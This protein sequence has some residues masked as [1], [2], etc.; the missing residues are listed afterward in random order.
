[1]KRFAWPN[2]SFQ[3]VGQCVWQRVFQCVLSRQSRCHL[4][5]AL[6]FTVLAAIPCLAAAPVRIAIVQGGGS[7]IEQDVVDRLTGQLQNMEDVVIS[8][9]N[10]DWYVVCNIQEKIDQLSGQVRYNGN[11]IVKTTDGQVLGTYAV[12]KYNQDFSLTPGASV[13]KALVDGAARDVI[14]QLVN[15]VLPPIQQA[16]QI[17]IETRE[18]VAR[19]NEL[20][21]QD[22]Y[23]DALSLLEPITPDTPHFKQVEKIEQQFQIEK[24]ALSLIEAGQDKQRSGHYLEAINLYRNVSA[25]S[26]RSKLAKEKIAQCSAAISH[27]PAGKASRNQ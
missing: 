17:E 18:R 3:C 6:A 8:T 20:A 19:A 10:P 22:K 2:Q 1:M 7:G 21:A 15:R 16:V 5:L 11:V 14:N 9:V 4:I 27:K 26:K 13:N 12:Q 23:E 24:K 25:Q